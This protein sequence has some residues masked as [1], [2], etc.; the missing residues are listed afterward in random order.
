[1]GRAVEALDLTDVLALLDGWERVAW[2]TQRLGPEGYR[3]FLQNA[4]DRTGL[5]GQG[6]AEFGVHEANALIRARLAAER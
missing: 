6:D 4:H 5:P 2:L 3:Q 1:M